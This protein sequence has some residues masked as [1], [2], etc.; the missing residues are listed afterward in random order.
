VI[1]VS[2]PEPADAPGIADLL[3]EL[4]EFYGVPPAGSPGE[5]ARQVS[6]A[7]F[8]SPPAAYALLARD[9]GKLAGL[10][11]YTFVWPAVGLTR[12][13]YLKELFVAGACR[14][15]GAGRLLMQAVFDTAARLGCSRV[16]WTTD[17]SNGQAQSF[18]AGLGL[19]VHP[20]KIFYRAEG[21]DSGVRLPGEQRAPESDS[22]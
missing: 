17:T 14:G 22:A 12:S 15:R 5:R 19:P 11:A 13:L 21:T 1:T 8:A 10:A 16:E 2:P 20:G 3:A 9:G 6:D 18:Y 4:S 7:L